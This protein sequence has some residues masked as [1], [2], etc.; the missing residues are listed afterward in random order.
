[1]LLLLPIHISTDLK[2][3]LSPYTF[4][5]ILSKNM[6]QKGPW[7]QTILFL[8]HLTNHKVKQLSSN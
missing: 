7:K 1:M 2:D 4:G 8:Y 5:S 6:T 3:I